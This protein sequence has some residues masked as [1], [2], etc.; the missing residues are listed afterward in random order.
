MHHVDI[1]F[2]ELAIHEVDTVNAYMPKFERNL[3]IVSEWQVAEI[4]HFED[5]LEIATH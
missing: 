4:V 5:I 2:G 1:S 3:E